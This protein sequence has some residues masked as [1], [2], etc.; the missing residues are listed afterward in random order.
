MGKVT[1]TSEEPR[2]S[3]LEKLS[4]MGIAYCG[5]GNIFDAEYAAR[6]LFYDIKNAYFISDVDASRKH[7]QWAHDE[8]H[9]GNWAVEEIGGLALNF[10]RYLNK[11]KA[12]TSPAWTL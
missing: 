12:C 5:D 11:D 4:Y 3:Y 10:E 8:I 1:F 7:W 2:E 9:S 6:E